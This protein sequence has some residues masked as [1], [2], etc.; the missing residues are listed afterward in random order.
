MQMPLSPVPMS[1]S[2]E[3]ELLLRCA[4]TDLDA[5]A[6]ERI[7]GSLGHD[8][9]WGRLLRTAFYH[10]V[11]PLLY[12]SLSA[13]CPEA[14]PE[15]AMG[16]LQGFYLFN[17]LRNSRRAQELLDLLEVF[18]AHGIDAIPFKGLVLA[19]AVYGSLHLRQFVDTDIL[20]RRSDVGRAGQLLLERGYERSVQEARMSE[21]QQEVYAQLTHQNAFWRRDE[22]VE[23]VIYVV[24]L[25]WGFASR[26]FSSPLDPRHVWARPGRG[27]LAG[28]PVPAF[29][30]EELVMFLCLHGAR[31]LWR[32]LQWVCDVAE[33]VRSCE[34]FDWPRLFERAQRLGMERM[35]LL[36][37]LL[38][39]NLLGAPLPGPS[40]ARLRAHP[41]VHV[42]AQEVQG[43][44]F[45]EGEAAPSML[46][47]RR[48]H[49]AARERARDKVRYAFFALTPTP[50]DWTFLALPKALSFVYYL[51]RPV[52]ILRDVLTNRR[53]RR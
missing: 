2:P 34:D 39:H 19:E 45:A 20:V 14:V 16:T 52:R 42:L 48:F 6:R 13:T 23:K 7:R 31:H 3:I 41:V 38:A 12:G 37:L 5:E 21:A 10:R 9:D 8:I 11:T 36:G 44:M 49:L 1:T 27:S 53:S 33:F 17:G 35:L 22:T 40:Q 51:L 25:Q 30:R 18:A 32:Q 26:Y 4:R 29:G 43:R 15:E 24:E 47:I 46:L 28:T 50:K